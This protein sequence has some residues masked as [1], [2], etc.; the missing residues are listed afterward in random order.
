MLSDRCLSCPI[1][2]VLSVIFG[3][4]WPN[5]WMGQ[6]EI[7]HAG[8]V[9]DGIQNPY[10]NG[11]QPIFIPYLLWPNGSMDEDATWYEGRPRPKRHCARWGPSSPTQKGG[12]SPNFWPM[13]IVPKRLDGSR[14]QLVWG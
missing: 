8:I 13:S 2:S 9:L 4:L 11:A 7:W 14:C 12:T 1:L 5:G 3:V 10:P 6:D